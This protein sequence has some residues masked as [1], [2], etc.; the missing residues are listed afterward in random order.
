MGRIRQILKN[1]LSMP[2]KNRTGTIQDEYL[3][4]KEDLGLNILNNNLS[5][6][7]KKEEKIMSSSLQIVNGEIVPV[8]GNGSS[9]MGANGIANQF[10]ADCIGKTIIWIKTERQDDESVIRDI[11]VEEGV[12][13][14]ILDDDSK[15]RCDYLGQYYDFP[16]MLNAQ[17]FDNPLIQ[18]QQINNIG[19]GM[20]GDFQRGFSNPVITS[21]SPVF[22]LLEKKKKNP[23][24][25]KVELLLD[26]PSKNLA[27]LLSD[28]FDNFEE[29]LLSYIL[30]NVN[31]NEMKEALRTQLK[32]HYGISEKEV[33]EE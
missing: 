9:I 18:N 28:E 17:A 27:K 10:F 6:I 31:M 1:V 14:F 15:A 22:A 4:R 19:N 11:T 25:I 32:L 20:G 30:S 29:E 5:N 33:V 2:S 3:K 21:K 23:Q 13:Y 8:S 26:I 16:E 7:S 24:R 12:E